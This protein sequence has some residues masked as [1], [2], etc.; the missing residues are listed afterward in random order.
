MENY[1]YYYFMV[2]D[3][4][5]LKKNNKCHSFLVPYDTF[6][7]LDPDSTGGRTPL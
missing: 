3:A 7:E 2:A 1:Y 5:R 6:L 4:E